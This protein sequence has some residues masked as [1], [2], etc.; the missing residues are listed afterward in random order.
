MKMKYQVIAINGDGEYIGY[1][2][3]VFDSKEEAE[4]FINIEYTQLFDETAEFVIV[5]LIEEN[6]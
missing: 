5:K 1:K 2:D 3:D 6:D 4:T